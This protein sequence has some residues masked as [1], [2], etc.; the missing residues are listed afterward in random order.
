MITKVVLKNFLPYRSAEVEVD[1]STI[2][3][4]GE[5]GHGKS[6]FLEAIPYAYFGIGRSTISGMSRLSGNGSHSVEVH[7]SGDSGSVVIRRGCKPSG[8]GFCT[9]H[10]DGEPVAKGAG[11][12]KWIE[13]YLGMD[14]DTYML[15]AFFGL[16]DTRHDVLINVLPS[17]RLETLQK[18]AKI[19]P[20]RAFENKA[21]IKMN[22]A[23]QN[24]EMYSSKAEGAEA[25]LVDV[26]S[27]EEV[28]ESLVSKETTLLKEISAF[29]DS[30]R[31]LRVDEE[32]YQTL[33]KEKERLHVERQSLQRDIRSD[34][35]EIETLEVSIADGSQTIDALIHDKA[36]K[37]AE[38]DKIDVD[39]LKLS[40]DTLHNA[41]V[42]TRTLIDLKKTAIGVDSD[43]CPLCGAE[44]YEDTVKQWIEDVSRLETELEEYSK[45]MSNDTASIA[46]ATSINRFLSTVASDIRRATEDIEE[47]KKR[48]ATLKRN[49]KRTR[50]EWDNKDSRYVDLS[51]KLGDEYQGLQ[52]KLESISDKITDLNLS[53]GNL[54]GELS[55]TK[56]RIRA[57]EKGAKEVKAYRKASEKYKVEASACKLLR[58]AW[59]RYGIP[60]SLVHGIAT[61]IEDRAS[62]V[63]QSFDNGRIEV[64]EVEDRG[65]PGIQFYLVDRKGE[66]TYGQLS[67]GEK[68]M[69]FVAVRVAIAHIVS[70]DVG[71][72]DYLIFD[73]AM[74]NL[75][76]RRRDDLIRLINKVLRKTFP[77]VFMVSHTEMRDIFTQ[78]I[79]IQEESGESRAVSV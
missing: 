64:R 43:T 51:E 4:V 69:F 11:A 13:A 12:T 61:Q 41:V 39:G 16:K 68:V 9:V 30:R 76:P 73:E 42:K 65:K 72:V 37:V 6:A 15:T 79:A 54:R 26:E 57:S 45:T 27:L 66:R 71:S 3:V 20:Y 46:T 29:K 36:S 56:A 49:L 52:H 1:N 22:E 60:L 34:N 62:S 48:L 53:L 74:G 33:V 40:I 35:S 77:Q 10:V 78:T 67:E 14:A 23:L 55:S 28:V 2:A 24:A 32:K 5:N 38:L 63:Y 25:V 8:S 44:L 75:S 31:G 19:G 70:S 50:N 7:E 58:E 17:A 59:N 18:L 21:K 47:D